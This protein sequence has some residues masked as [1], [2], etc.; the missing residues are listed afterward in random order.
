VTVVPIEKNELGCFNLW[1]PF[2]QRLFTA[3]AYAFDF[4]DENVVVREYFSADGKYEAHDLSLTQ[5]FFKSEGLDKIKFEN[6]K[7]TW[8]ALWKY[9]PSTETKENL[10]PLIAVLRQFALLKK[11]SIKPWEFDCLLATLCS[12]DVEGASK[13][14][15]LGEKGGEKRN[16]MFS[17]DLNVIASQFQS[18]LILAQY[19]NA[20][21]GLPFKEFGELYYLFSGFRFQAYYAK[22]AAFMKDKTEY[23]IGALMGQL[24]IPTQSKN[25]IAAMRKE[26]FRELK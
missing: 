22:A 6:T 12:K 2:R 9:T 5:D 10:V 25:R 8:L 14:E 24:Q 13:L 26:I 18:G 11:K 17:I 19:T 3:F 15:N 23:N 7:Q 21:L 1:T 16:K 20:A 4:K